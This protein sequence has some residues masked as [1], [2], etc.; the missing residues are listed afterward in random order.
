L[1]AQKLIDAIEEAGY[2]AKEAMP[3]IS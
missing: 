1:M 3:E 2:E